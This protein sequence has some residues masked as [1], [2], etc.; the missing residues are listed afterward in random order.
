MLDHFWLVL[1]T[2]TQQSGNSKLSGCSGRHGGQTVEVN[3]QGLRGLCVSTVCKRGSYHARTSPLSEGHTLLCPTS[4]QKRACLI[5]T[6]Y[7]FCRP[8]LRPLGKL[9]QQPR[10]SWRLH[11]VLAAYDLWPHAPKEAQLLEEP[12][13][14]KPAVQRPQ[15]VPLTATWCRW[16]GCWSRAMPPATENLS[17]YKAAPAQLLG[18]EVST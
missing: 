7:G 15:Q 9:L 3:L 17:L 1:L 11:A 2:W 8:P 16:L 5:G 10:V 6:L 12:G 4:L 14:D 13:V 18:Q